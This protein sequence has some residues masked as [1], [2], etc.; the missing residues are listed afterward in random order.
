MKGNEQGKSCASRVSTHLVSTLFESDDDSCEDE[1]STTIDLV[2][3]ECNNPFSIRCLFVL[4][5]FLSSKFIAEVKKL[6]A[7]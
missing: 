4:D 7:A 1:L 6:S 3:K 5:V 2:V